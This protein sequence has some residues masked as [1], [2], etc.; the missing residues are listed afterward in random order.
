MAG[1]SSGC[2]SLQQRTEARGSAP[3]AA[4]R[5]PSM[6]AAP[7]SATTC[8][9]REM[10]HS[11]GSAR[12]AARAPAA[13]ACARSRPHRRAAP[14]AACELDG[15]RRAPGARAEHG[16]AGSVVGLA[17]M[18]RLP[19]L[20][21]GDGRLPRSATAYSASKF[22]GGSRNCG[23]PP[24]LTSCETAARAYGN[25]TP[26]HTVLMARFSSSRRQIAHHERRR[27]ALT[28]TRNIV[29][30]PCLA[31]TVTVST[32]SRTSPAERLPRW[33]AGRG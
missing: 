29:G 20:S 9:G 31:E 6:T 21:F 3:P 13:R 28:S 19:E 24:W 11:A 32:T 22:T 2:S 27:P 16:D 14:A 18:L 25:S 12:C 1:G 8:S 30:S 33:F 26:G 7:A 10:R 15:E 5:A 17:V 23:K 4:H